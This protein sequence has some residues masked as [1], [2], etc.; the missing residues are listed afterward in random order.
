MSDLIEQRRSYTVGTEIQMIREGAADRLRRE[1]G[2]KM[3]A[4]WLVVIISNLPFSLARSRVEY[5]RVVGNLE[6]V[7]YIGIYI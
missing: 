3:D 1:G 4:C 2:Y 5:L 6:M 7:E